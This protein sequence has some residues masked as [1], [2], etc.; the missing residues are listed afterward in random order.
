MNNYLALPY[1]LNKL[2]TRLLRHEAIG[3]GDLALLEKGV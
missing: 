1:E 2:T 3:Q